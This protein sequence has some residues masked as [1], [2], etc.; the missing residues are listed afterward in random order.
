MKKILCLI[1]IL[2]IGTYIFYNIESKKEHT[3][4]AKEEK[5]LEQEVTEPESYEIKNSV[6]MQGKLDM[7]EDETDLEL[8]NSLHIYNNKVIDIDDVMAAEIIS[9]LKENG[10][11]NHSFETI[12]EGVYLIKGGQ[13]GEGINELSVFEQTAIDFMNDSGISELLNKNKIEFEWEIEDQGS[14]YTA[15]CFLLSE[16]KRTGSYI[17]MNF[18]SKESCGE[19]MLFLY[20]SEVI[21]TLERISA[22]EALKKAFYIDEENKEDK[23]T[24]YEE[25]NIRA[26]KIKYINGLPYYS[27]SAYG[28]NNRLLIHG[29]ALAIDMEQSK[30]QEI[31]GEKYKNFSLE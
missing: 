4:S 24:D 10:W 7:L 18:E 9:N 20:D 12:G 26:L 23:P 2:T 15:Y 16:G 11:G 14:L 17:R 29:Y 5:Q 3:S 27:F 31:I 28:V 22:K 6:L 21:E 30:H 13:N 8:E 1:S 25:Y 19:C